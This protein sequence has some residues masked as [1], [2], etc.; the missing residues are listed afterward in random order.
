MTTRSLL[1]INYHSAL[2][3][4]AAIRTARAA[5][6]EPLQIVVVDNSVSGS[7]VGILRQHADAVI[8][9]PRNLG[10]AGGIN[11]GRAVCEGDVII[12]SN[13]DV[14]FGAAAIDLLVDAD[15]A[16]SGPAL[17]WDDDYRWMLP[18]AELHTAREV[19]DRVLAS[20]SRAWARMRDRRRFFA[21]VAFW[22]LQTPAIIRALSGAVM[23]IR[24]GAFDAAGG[25]DTRFPLYFEENDFLRR[26][27]G[28][29]AYVPAARC[30]HLY[31]QSAGASAEASSF[32]A[33]SEQ[34]YLT[35][36]GG[37]FVKRFEK[38]SPIDANPRPDRSGIHDFAFD[39]GDVVVEASP[40]PN[41]E[42]TAG[43]FTNDPYADVPPEVWRS[44][45]GDVLYL[46]AFHR[47]SGRLLRSWAKAR[48]P[49]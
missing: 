8:A 44:Y 3:A 15:A 36:W 42:N 49:A 16:V 31:N 43:R 48:I 11:A 39:D 34:L 21:R 24:A 23:A 35:K 25:F 27:R 1:I 7:E 37:S 12:V 22:S 5:S 47:E 46:R 33:Q 28:T 40:L 41:F 38:H 4:V 19:A 6:S 10:Y 18:P 2:L 45:R 29:I 26:V 20:R 13:P 14:R 32:Y 17:F 9:A 30:R